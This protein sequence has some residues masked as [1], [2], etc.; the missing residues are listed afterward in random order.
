MN[1]ELFARNL[2]DIVRESRIRQNIIAQ[3]L[4]ISSAAISQF[5]HGTALPKPTQL[6]ELLTLLCVSDRERSWMLHLLKL[7]KAEADAEGLSMEVVEDPD[8]VE[9]EDEDDD[10]EI[11]EEESS[12]QDSLDGYFE[13]RGKKSKG[14][15]KGKKAKDPGDAGDDDAPADASGEVSPAPAEPSAKRIPEKAEKTARKK[16]AAPKGNMPP[17]KQKKNPPPVIMDGDD[18]EDT[19]RPR[20]AGSCSGKIFMSDVPA[21]GVPIINLYDLDNY[22]TG[23]S[24][25]DYAN[26]CLHDTVIRNYGSVGAPVIVKTTGDQLG[27]N[28]LGPVQ[29]VLVADMAPEMSMMSLSRYSNNAYRLVPTGEENDIFGIRIFSDGVEYPKCS[30]IWTFPLLEITFIPF[31][32]NIWD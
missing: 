21:D 2:Y 32:F 24:L 27:L 14:K 9:E 3:V 11:A 7:A 17:P 5:T 8:A 10:G 6:S 13:K 22:D 29:M 1:R 16:V 4:G 25:I 28:Y 31:G 19:Y 23:M 15:G 12:D 18:D 20:N 30:P 26:A